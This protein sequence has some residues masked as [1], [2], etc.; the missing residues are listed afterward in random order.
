MHKNPIFKNYKKKISFFKNASS[1]EI[2]C[3]RPIMFVVKHDWYVSLRQC[4]CSPGSST[5]AD[6]TPCGDSDTDESGAGQRVTGAC[7]NSVAFLK[8]ECF[9]FSP[10]LTP[11]NAG[12]SPSLPQ[13]A[14]ELPLNNTGSCRAGGRG[15]GGGGRRQ[16][17]IIISQQWATKPWPW[18]GPYFFGQGGSKTS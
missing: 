14:A 5:G 13:R 18:K 6:V 16:T 9:G 2:A 8:H 15:I 12:S 4:M 17:I 7:L 1:R 10:F 11:F 3:K